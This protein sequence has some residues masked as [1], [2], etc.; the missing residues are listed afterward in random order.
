MKD[1]I[2]KFLKRLCPHRWVEI[3]VMVVIN[4]YDPVDDVF[5]KRFVYAPEYY[6]LICKEKRS[7]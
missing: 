3:K 6:C 4:Q 5:N 1:K 7:A 2:V